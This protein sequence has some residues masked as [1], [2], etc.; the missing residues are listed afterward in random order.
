MTQWGQERVLGMLSL[1]SK[2]KVFHIFR[3]LW[4]SSHYPGHVQ[5]LKTKC[6]TSSQQKRTGRWEKEVTV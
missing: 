4:V 3:E 6:L 1:T 5:A 2:E